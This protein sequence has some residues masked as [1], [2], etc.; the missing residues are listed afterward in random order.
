MFLFSP[1]HAT[2][3]AHLIHLGL[4]TVT[5]Y[6]EE[7]IL[8]YPT[9]RSF[10]HPPVT[11]THLGINKYHTPLFSNTLHLLFGILIFTYILTYLLTYL[12]HAAESSLRN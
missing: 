3:P 11:S 1:M 12:L 8:L 4:I 6:D 7:Y 5:I 10:L 9:S 2:C